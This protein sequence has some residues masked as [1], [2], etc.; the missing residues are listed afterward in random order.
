MDSE[1]KLRSNVLK[2]AADLAGLKSEQDFTR[3]VETLGATETAVNDLTLDQ[4]RSLMISALE[5][6]NAEV[7]SQNSSVVTDALTH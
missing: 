7:T 4:L 6:I 2:T 1:L 3:V 5:A